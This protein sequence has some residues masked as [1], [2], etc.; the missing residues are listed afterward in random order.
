MGTSRQTGSRPEMKCEF[1]GG[2]TTGYRARFCTPSCA[3][4]WRA[5]QPGYKERMSA[6]GQ[7]G[8]E[9]RTPEGMA[10]TAAAARKRMLS[11]ANPMH[12]PLVRGKVSAA[13]RGRPFPT[14]RGGNGKPLPEPQQKL[15]ELTKLIPEHP[16]GVPEWVRQTLGTR[17]KKLTVDL[18]DPTARVAV[19]VDGNSHKALKVRRADETKNRVLALLDWKVL[20]FKNAEV[21]A[22][23]AKCAL[24]VLQTVA[25]RSS[26]SK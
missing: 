24:T 26:T 16:V 5:Q 10:R 17:T 14:A 12:D 19:E 20:R 2:P 4:K 13:L 23:P 21:L 1:C 9:M 25:S 22:D 8:A 3:G 11:T 18:A 15:W 7:K 6:A